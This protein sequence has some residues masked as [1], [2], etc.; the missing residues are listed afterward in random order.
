MEITV[1]YFLW[2]LCWW[3]SQETNNQALTF[4]FISLLLKWRNPLWIKL[5]SKGISCHISDSLRNKKRRTS[6]KHSEKGVTAPTHS[7]FM[8]PLLFFHNNKKKKKHSQTLTH[9]CEDVVKHFGHA[10]LLWPKEED[11][12]LNHGWLYDTC[13]QTWVNWVPQCHVFIKARRKLLLPWRSFH[14]LCSGMT[15]LLSQIS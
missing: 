8:K 9:L 2:I 15:P 10:V 11:S 14:L 1:C 7:N 6:H 4:S 3:E 5:S 12:A 13:V